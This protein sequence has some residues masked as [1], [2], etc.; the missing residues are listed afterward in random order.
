V[1]LARR[2]DPVLI[3]TIPFARDMSK[4]IQHGCDLVITVADGHPTNNL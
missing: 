1:I 2:G 4:P 3:P